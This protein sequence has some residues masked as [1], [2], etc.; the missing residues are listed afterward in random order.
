M[1][2]VVYIIPLL[3]TLSFT[4]PA[5][6]NGAKAATILKKVSA[7]YKK[8]KTMKSTFTIKSTDR[9]DKSTKSSGT[10]W[11]KGPKFKLDYAGQIIYCDG[12]HTWTYNPTDKEVTKEKYKKKKGSI[13]PSDIFSVYKKDFKNAYS[14]NS[15]VSGVN[16][17][18]IKMV[19]K[20]RRNYSYLKLYVNQKT[21]KISKLSQYYKNGSTMSVV[22]SKF[23]PNPKV[24]DAYFEW[25]AGKNKDVE[26]VDLSN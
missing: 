8:Y 6:V 12:K 17:Y 25:N 21:N 4:V 18:V 13:S 10:L 2:K 22:V 26:L 14:G 23:V 3:L 7:V 5:N 1:R 20:K 16:N 9:N 11:L 24:T 19:P 15:K